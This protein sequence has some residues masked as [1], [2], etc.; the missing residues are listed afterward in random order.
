MM[1]LCIMPAALHACGNAVLLEAHVN[2]AVITL[3][4]LHRQSHEVSRSDWFW[5]CA[6][7]LF[8]VQHKT[9]RS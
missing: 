1:R 3:A 8:S 9:W 7:L 5:C 6:L 2:T 4:C